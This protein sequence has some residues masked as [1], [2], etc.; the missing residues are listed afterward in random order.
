MVIKNNQPMHN[1]KKSLVVALMALSTLTI[2]AANYTHSVGAVVGSRN[3]VQYK[4][5]I[6]GIDHL[7]L[8]ADLGINLL[9]TQFG[10]EGIP[11]YSE[12]AWILEVNPNLVY[13]STLATWGFGDLDIMTGGGLSLGM[14]SN[15]EG[16]K[17]GYL[18]NGKFGINALVGIE[19]GFNDM[20]LVLGFDFRPGYGMTFQDEYGRS[21]F[22]W[23]LNVGLRYCF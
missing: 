21:F 8:Q 11:S 20:P 5:F 6:L 7:A 18:Y 14:R 16:Y 3:G 15:L 22:D 10:R 12:S 4:G 19:L 2:S 23:S 9:Q 13:Q 17:Y 1:M